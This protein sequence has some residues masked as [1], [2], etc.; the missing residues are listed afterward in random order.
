MSRA[1]NQKHKLIRLLQILND[2]TDEDRG[3][4]MPE[5]ISALEEY[6]IKAERK[7]V[8]DD[9]LSLEELG[10]ATEKLPTRPPQYTLSERIFELPELKLLV[11][12]VQSSK[13]IT[14]EYSTRIIDKL[15]SF[16]GAHRRGELT[17]QVYVEGRA[18][19]MNKATIYTID[20]IHEAINL[21]RQITFKYFDYDSKKQR[22]LRHDGRTYRVSPTALIWNMEYYYL[23]AYDELNGNRRNYRVDKMVDIKVSDDPFSK[24]ALEEGFNSADYTQKIFGMYGGRE[25]L[26]SFECRESLAGVM[27]DRFGTEPAFHKTERGFRFSAHVMVSP[28][29]FAWVMSFGSQVEILSPEWVREKYLDELKATLDIYA[30]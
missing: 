5:I 27:I 17:R 2:R 23:V 15:K 10:F 30:K 21:G 20:T 1:E 22:V 29:F 14:A 11:D 6:G 7:S 18:K 13:F 25:E 24:E 4:T 3:L 9:L 8:Y 26:V 12:A 19:T 28:N 16:A